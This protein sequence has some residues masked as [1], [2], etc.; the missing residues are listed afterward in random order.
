MSV[1]EAVANVGV[2]FLVALLMQFIVFPMFGLEVSLSENLAIG[3]LFTIASI[4]RSYALRRASE[5]I[6]AHNANEDCRRRSAEAA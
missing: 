5:A 1:V 2:G 6:R 3:A 4:A